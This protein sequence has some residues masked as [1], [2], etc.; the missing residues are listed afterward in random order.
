METIAQSSLITHRLDDLIAKLKDPDRDEHALLVEHLQTAHAYFYGSMPI[1]CLV[2][3]E[4]ARKAAG[5]VED[6]SL[7]QECRAVIADLLDELKITKDS[8]SA[9]N[10]TQEINSYPV[11]KRLLARQPYGPK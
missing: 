4:M 2:N 11:P 10:P 7:R 6:R 5:D 8:T 3:L 9:G 1:E